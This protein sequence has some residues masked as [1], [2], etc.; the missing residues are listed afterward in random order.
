M[1]KG[2]PRT[3]V[4]AGGVKDPFPR[5]LVEMGLNQ[6]R[7]AET[8]KYAH[9][10]F[11]YNGGYREPLDRKLEE[12]VLIPSD[13]I[14]SFAKAPQMKAREIGEKAKQLILSGKFQ[15][16]LINFANTDMVGHTGNLAAVIRAAEAV[17]GALGVITAALAQVG[18]TA[19]ITADHGNG[20]EMISSNPK[21]G[22]R[23]PNT[24]H[25]LN[26][27]PAILFDPKY[28]GAADYTLRPLEGAQATGAQAT[29][30]QAN[31][32]SRVAATNA[33][34]LGMM[35]PDDMDGPL[36]EIN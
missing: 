21:T 34:M 6:F 11:F 25:S 15:Y 24:R 22:K 8:Q 30:V 29:G 36:F 12:Y 23:E 5:R 16:G 13:R 4:A 7:L 3:L 28:A 20:D 32:L 27:V 19:L 1:T 9:V 10:T 14:D 26:P 35:P 18:G 17:D 31:T 33:L 2:P